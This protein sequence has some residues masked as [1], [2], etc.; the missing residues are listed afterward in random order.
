[1]EDEKYK[2]IIKDI[3]TLLNDICD[4]GRMKYHII[5]VVK[6]S[7]EMAKKL[8]ADIQVVEIS[9]YLHDVT[10]ILGDKKNHHIT[11]AQY[12]R[13]FLQKYD[14]DN[15]KIKLIE[16]CIKN[17]RGSTNSRRKTIEEKIISTAD[18]ISHIEYPLPLFYTWYGKR[19]CTIENGAIEIKSKLQRSWNKI[20]FKYKKDEIKNKYNY[21]MEVLSNNE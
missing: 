20:E 12:A 15:K 9:A 19:K 2:N 10:K 14:F 17:H 1:M 6:I 16:T 5:P 21:L 13:E 7:L 4:D 3:N 8:N 11:G 18:A